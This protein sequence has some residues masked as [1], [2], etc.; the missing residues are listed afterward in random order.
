MSARANVAVEI[1]DVS[2]VRIRRIDQGVRD[3]G[4]YAVEWD[5]RDNAGNVVGT[6]VYFYRLEGVAGVAPRKMVLVK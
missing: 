2:G 1:Y 5:G 6:G 3:A 4:E